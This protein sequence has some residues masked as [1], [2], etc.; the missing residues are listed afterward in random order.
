MSESIKHS[1][2]IIA[3]TSVKKPYGWLGNMSPFPIVYDEERWNTTEALFQALRFREDSHIREAIR[4]AN[5][6]MSA[7][8]TATKNK[9]SMIVV[10]GSEEDFDNMRLCLRLKLEQHPHLVEELLGTGERIII[11]DCSDRKASIWGAQLRFSLQDPHSGEWVGSNILGK[12]WMELRT[13]L[14]KKGKSK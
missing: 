9:G 3:F 4:A 13:S 11:E 8:F 12:L 10:R 7:K 14:R 2:D 1:E 6:P 5:S